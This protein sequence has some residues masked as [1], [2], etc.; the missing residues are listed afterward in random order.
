MIATPPLLRK[1]LL[2]VV[3]SAAAL[4]LLCEGAPAAHTADAHSAQHAEADENN[5]RLRGVCPQHGADAALQ[6]GNIW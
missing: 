6:Q 4:H 2:E 3:D 5:E 1:A